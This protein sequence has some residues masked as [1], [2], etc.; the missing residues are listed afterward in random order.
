MTDKNSKG[1]N[2]PVADNLPEKEKLAKEKRLDEVIAAFVD[3]A[4]AKGWAWHLDAKDRKNFCYATL[5]AERNDACA[6]FEITC[7]EKVVLAAHATTFHA[8]GISAL[9]DAAWNEICKLPWLKSSAKDKKSPPDWSIEI[10][11]KLLRNFHRMARQIKH[12][13]DN[14]PAFLINDEYDIQDLL[15]TVLRGFFDDIRPEEYT[16]SYAGSASRLDFLLKKEEI[17]IETKM[18]STKL[19]DKQV[20]E[21]L[22][23]DIAKYK[24][25][26]DC[27]LLVC[28]VYDPYNNLKNPAGLEAD[29]S[30]KYD[31]LNVKVTVVSPS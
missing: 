21:Q 13:H 19:R 10:I 25:H 12:R 15:H 6:T 20:G 28:F 9:R 4:E 17:I 27:K 14:R 1:K 16:P 7:D 8:Y 26:P 22:I 5:S 11:E 23:I 2:S 18:A 3:A 29:L 24:C 31:T 30:K